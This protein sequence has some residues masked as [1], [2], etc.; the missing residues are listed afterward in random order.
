MYIHILWFQRLHHYQGTQLKFGA[1]GSLHV[2]YMCMVVFIHV[3]IYLI[4]I[5]FKYSHLG[6]GVGGEGYVGKRG[7]IIIILAGII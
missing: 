7:Q 1:T 5:V 3:C 6:E 4:H 2:Q